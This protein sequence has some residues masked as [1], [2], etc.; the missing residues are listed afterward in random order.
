MAANMRQNNPTTLKMKDEEGRVYSVKVSLKYIPVEMALDASESINNM[1][2]LRIDVLD[3]QGLPAADAN[4][5]SDPYVKF[6]LNGEEVFKTKVQKKTLN[7]AWNEFFEVSVPS[8]TGA[9]FKA[10]VMDWDF[11]NPDDFLGEASIS[12]ANLE[13]FKAQE[14]RLPLE[15]KSGSVRLRLLFRPDYITRTRQGSSTFHGTFAAPGKMVTGVAGAP[16]KGGAAVAHGVGK[17]ASFLKRGFRTKT[18]KE[19][20]EDGLT[21]ATTATEVPT[22]TTTNSSDPSAGF[23]LRRPPALTLTDSDT[24][25]STPPETTPPEPANGESVRHSRTKSMSGSS[26][27]SALVPGVATGTASFTVVSATGFPPSSDIYVTV[28]QVKDGKS[29][30]IG[31][32]KHHKSPAGTAHFEETFKISCTPDCQF[33]LEAKEHNTFSSDD[34]LG[35]SLY[36]V[37]DSNSEHEK[38]IKVGTGTIVMRS[39]FHPTESSPTTESPKNTSLRRSFLSKKDKDSKPTSRESTPVS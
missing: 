6:D 20:D 15:G 5:K 37:D 2:N 26:V 11:G 17:G 14:I 3:A 8:R 19:G 22:I 4:G 1:G 32:T 39:S 21:P 12:L 9:K 35:S 7:P 23:G 27:H 16:M 13:P 34:D 10:T 25:P 24:A 36:F 38:D 18:A 29:K 30:T 28:A 31:K 33:K